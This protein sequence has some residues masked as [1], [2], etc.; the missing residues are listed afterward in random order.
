MAKLEVIANA[1]MCF[2]KNKI[3]VMLVNN[4]DDQSKFYHNRQ[5]WCN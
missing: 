3:F 1:Q 2:W 5:K 4:N